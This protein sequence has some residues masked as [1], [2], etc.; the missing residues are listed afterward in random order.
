MS[1]KSD[2][3]VPVDGAAVAVIG[4]GIIGCSVAYH[5]ARAGVTNVM[6]IE[7]DEV[8]TA[9]TA[10]SAGMLSHARADRHLIAMVRRTRAAIEELEN[11]FGEEIGFRQVGT[12]RAAFSD[13]REQELSRVEAIMMA[14]GV[15][16]DPITPSEAHRLC[17]WLDAGRANRITFVADDGY[18][19]APRLAWAYARSARKLGVR[20]LR[21]VEVLGFEVEGSRITGALTTSGSIKTRMIVSTAGPW[22]N[23]IAVWAGR[24]AAAAPTRSHYWLTAPDGAGPPDQASVSL[25]DYGVYI[26]SELGGLLIGVHEPNTR[27]MD[28]ASLPRDLE[29]VNLTD[30]GDLGIL[31]EQLG[32][33][34]DIIPDVDRWGFAHHIAGLSMY[35]PDGRFLIGGFGGL[36]GFLV[37][38][39]CCGSGVAASGGIG[40]LVTDLILERSPAVDAAL[41]SPDRF[42][43]VNPSAPEFRASCAAARY[44]K[45]RF[46]A[47]S[48][49]IK[50]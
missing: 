20:F 38:A 14:E 8:A 17:R 31:T 3:Q 34:R 41:F 18:L 7:R 15:V 32:A 22:S 27:T 36:E 45:S 23:Q 21:G 2:V 29:A 39:G 26:R 4:G 1:M 11:S 44:R 10:R 35:T 24:A 48:T 16:F 9:T 12:I 40:A 5:L 42:G 30:D 46:G 25:P 6:V 19:D 43:S 50:G 13:A 47:G 49:S 28:P 37:A 33:L